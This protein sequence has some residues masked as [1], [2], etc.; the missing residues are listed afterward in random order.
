M[1]ELEHV[2]AVGGRLSI[3][4]SGRDVI[5][6]T[7]SRTLDLLANK[8]WDHKWRIATFD[9]PEKYA[10]LRNKVRDILK[11]AGFVKLQHSVWIFPHDCEELVQLLKKESQLSN[12]ILYGVLE[13]IEDEERLKKLFQL[14]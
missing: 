11:K 14:G 10:A 5:G 4:K 8:K 9:I 6:V 12:Y 7:I 2:R 1:I 3:T 13:R